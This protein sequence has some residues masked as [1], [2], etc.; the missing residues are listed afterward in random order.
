MPTSSAPN[1][2]DLPNAVAR[3][4]VTYRLVNEAGHTLCRGF[5]GEFSRFESAPRHADA[6]EFP[7][8]HVALRVAELVEARVRQRYAPL[9]KPFSLCPVV[10][11]WS[12]IP[13]GWWEG[14]AGVNATAID[15]AQLELGEPLI[16]ACRRRSS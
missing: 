4:L 5:Q 15:T 6:A 11:D 3:P 1:L 10:K 9:P 8:E 13:N 16:A 12:G 2:S 14:K 7:S